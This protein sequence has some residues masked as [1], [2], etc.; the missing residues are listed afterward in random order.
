M[1]G[2]TGSYEEDDGGFQF[3]R[4]DTKKPKSS[5]EQQPIPSPIK[6]NA[7]LSPRRGRPPKTKD[8]KDSRSPAT[9]GE[10]P[11]LGVVSTKPQRGRPKRVPEESYNEGDRNNRTLNRSEAEQLIPEAKSRHRGRQ[12]KSKETQQN[13]FISPEQSQIMTTSKIALPFADTPVIRRNKEMREKGASK[14]QRRS[15]LGMRGR[16][17]SSLIESGASNGKDTL[18][19]AILDPDTE[20][21]TDFKLSPSTPTQRSFHF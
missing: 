17:A 20:Q 16:R 8:H 7:P 4:K 3:S 2:S 18:L 5:S 21:N 9:I 15:S 10:S 19:T 12:E 13:G 11:T 14:G 6:S 1:D